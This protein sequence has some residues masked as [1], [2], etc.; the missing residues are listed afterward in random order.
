MRRVY[1]DH[2]ATTPMRPEV[3][4]AM[5]PFL[6]DQYGNP[7]SV[8]G[9]GQQAKRALE[10]AREKIAAAIGA[11]PEEIIFTSGGTEADNL[12]IIGAALAYQKKGR[13]VI[14]SSIEH[15]AA[16]DSAKH[17]EKIGFK[18]TFL[19]VTPEGLVQVSDVEEAITPETI[20][21]SV[22][23]V[24]NEVGTIQPVAEIGRLAHAHGII[25]HTDAV[26][27]LG[28]LP[29]DV[30]NLQADL[31]SIS[32]HKI[33]GPK[34]VGALYVR[35]GVRL[36][37][38]L[39]GGGQ[40]RKRRPGTENIPG[41]V[42]FGRAAE[43]AVAEMPAESRRLAALRDRL[44]DKIMS[45]IDHVVLTGHRSQRVYNHASFWMEYVEGESMLLSLDM[46]GVAASSGSACTSGSLDPS[47]VLLAMGL[48]P[49]VA[50]GSLRFSLGRDN[51]EE[52]IDY[53]AAILPGIVAR[54]RAMSPLYEAVAGEER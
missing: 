42:G 32:A 28:K 49:E 21:I 12:A 40:E 1:L 51:T 16:L 5:L 41:I 7:S 44:I 23:H 39:H 38:L 53:V 13:H 11:K 17:L 6:E 22:M 50:H 46:Q 20:L 3:K 31:L 15:H 52:D 9:W 19:P 36:E 43:L 35:R 45:S 18:V 24:N 4:E 10:E 2:S 8:H 34:G 33:Y 54:L 14:T 48:P 26:Q 27:S 47:H 29:V 30:N 37:P 25:F